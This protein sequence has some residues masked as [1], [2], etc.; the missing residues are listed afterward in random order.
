ME[1][2]V[3]VFE[4]PTRA[5]LGRALASPRAWLLG[6]L[7]LGAAAAGIRW[8][9]RPA[10]PTVAEGESPL[11]VET[12]PPGATIVV[13]GRERGRT[14]ATVGVAPGG[15]E[16]LVRRDGAL[17]ERRQ[18]P[19]ASGSQVRTRLWRAAPVTKV[20]RSVGIDAGVR[21]EGYGADQLAGRV[22]MLM[23]ALERR[24]GPLY[25]VARLLDAF[26]AAQLRAL[27]ASARAG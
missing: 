18:V 14:P 24:E 27:V 15:H 23:R 19:L 1:L 22:A 25:G 7:L 4:P 9:A 2:P 20:V 26:D 11:R 16:L 8:L 10:G 13:D 21:W 12:A 5:D 3:V 6:L 17:D